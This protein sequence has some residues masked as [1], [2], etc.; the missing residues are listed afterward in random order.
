VSGVKSWLATRD[1]EQ[2]NGK[3]EVLYNHDAFISLGVK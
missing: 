1:W 2:I 3:M